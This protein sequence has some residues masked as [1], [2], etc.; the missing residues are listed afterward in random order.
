MKKVFL[1]ARYLLALMLLVFGANKF[2][3]FMPFPPLEGFAVDY[4]K[5]IAGSYILKTLGILYIA[6]G[7]ML[8]V[9]KMVGL[10]TILVAPLAFNAFMFHLT[11][12]PANIAGAAIFVV[13]TVVVM[14]GNKGAYK[15]LLA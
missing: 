5:V 11:L 12:D 15:A 14:I 10:A 1:I 7:I 2:L 3:G 8:A 13:L 6:S 4:M 9:N